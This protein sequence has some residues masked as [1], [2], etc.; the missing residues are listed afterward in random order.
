M[1]VKIKTVKAK[2][3]KPSP[4]EVDQLA[5]DYFSE[6]DRAV[7]ASSKLE[8]MKEDLKSYARAKGTQV[9]KGVYA[10]GDRF[11]LGISYADKPA[12]IDSA[13]LKTLVSPATYKALCKPPE[14][15]SKM[16]SQMAL[17]GRIPPKVVKQVLVI[18]T[19]KIERIYVG[20]IER[21]PDAYT[22]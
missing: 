15:D 16:F 6:R 13:L 8:A 14:I 9:S 4:A 22:S 19:D 18:P 3:S 20:D 1:K 10:T 21:S 7:A 17:E 12:R 5:R 11:R 2:F